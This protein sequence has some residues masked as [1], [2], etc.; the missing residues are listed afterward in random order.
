MSCCFFLNEIILDNVKRKK[1][2]SKGA[3]M[4]LSVLATVAASIWLWR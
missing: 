2:E 4:I 1:R 3:S